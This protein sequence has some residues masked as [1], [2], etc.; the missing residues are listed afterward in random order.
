V[1]SRTYPRWPLYVWAGG[2]ALLGAL[3]AFVAVTLEYESGELIGHTSQAQPRIGKAAY[4]SHV[5]G[6][7]LS[8]EQQC[9][10]KGT[11]CARMLLNA[12]NNDRT[13]HGAGALTLD[14]TQSHGTASCPGSVGHSRHMA[15]TG[16]LAH[17]QFPADLCIPFR[18]AGENIAEAGGNKAD[19][20]LTGL[21]LMLSE[22]WSPG[23]TWNHACNIR[24]PQFTTIG[25][26][27]AYGRG[28]WFQTMSFVGN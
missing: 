21:Q 27:Y 3:I 6:V 8:A 24:N 23:C 11:G 4:I 22:N 2:T 26:G 13:T 25:L 7:G 1:A 15:E 5:P 12:L 28:A 10:T 20:I 18:S 14:W 16:V 9:R 19:A 17:D